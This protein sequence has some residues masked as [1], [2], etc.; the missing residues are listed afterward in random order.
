LGVPVIKSLKKKH[1]QKITDWVSSGEVIPVN[2]PD[3]TETVL[4]DIIAIEAKARIDKM[5]LTGKQSD[6][7]IS[8][9]T[10]FLKKL[11]KI[12]SGRF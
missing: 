8:D 4:R 5:T 10:N 1:L 9:K 3:I 7:Q 2:Y 11:N 6:F 12:A